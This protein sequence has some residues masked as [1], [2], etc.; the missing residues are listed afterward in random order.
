MCAALMGSCTNS[1]SPNST[2]PQQIPAWNTAVALQS[3]GPSTTF[4]NFGKAITTDGEGFV[5]VVW[6]QGG[7]TDNDGSF[8]SVGTGS[9]L[10]AQSADQGASWSTSSLTVAAPNTSLPKIASAGSNIYV[11][12]PA[13]NVAT[14]NLQIFLVHGTR[15]GSQIQWSTP[16]VISDT[17]TGANAIFPVTAAF[18][19]QI[20]VA[21]SDTRNAGVS[22]VYYTGS[23]DNGSMWSKPVGV[24]PVDGF[25]SW[26][27]SIAA[28]SSHVFIAGLMPGSG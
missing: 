28:D 4:G 9:I 12:W 23:S 8:I 7:S 10:F 1:S 18:D 17:P 2:S 21:W 19:D 26:T 5:D 11:V 24:S 25:N 27:P 14:G 15:N 13:Q 6:L 20:H 16:M 3:R 22:E